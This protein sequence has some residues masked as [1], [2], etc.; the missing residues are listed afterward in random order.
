[1]NIRVVGAALLI[2]LCA[3]GGT[4]AAQGKGTENQDAKTERHGWLGVAV[5]DLTPRTSRE[6]GL[7]V[8]T[9]ALVNGVT[10]E[11][12]AEE[13][14]I[15]EDDVIVEFN[16]RSIDDADDLLAA[17]RGASAGDRATVTL[18]RGKE[19]TT[20][21]VTLG[22][23]PRRGFAFSYRG[24]GRMMIPPFGPMRELR[25]DHTDGI[26]GLWLTDLHR[27]LGEYFGAPGGRGVLIEE[28]EPKSEGER[29]GFKAGDVIISA[30]TTSVETTG[31]I[32]DAVEGSKK[33]DKIEFGVLR[34]GEHLTLTAESEGPAEHRRGGF[35]SFRF[36]GEARPGFEPDRLKLEMER[37]RDG[38]REIGTRIRTEMR[39][40]GR[41]LRSVTS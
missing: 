22:R 26:S 35:R 7:P 15:K 14:G 41:K 36:N 40:L 27:Q 3:T 28:V 24:P 31:D 38:L 17:V 23:A 6:K 13:A 16:G 5:Q 29:A 10:E 25:M 11:S 19:K 8:K 21:Q 37:L 32:A 33:G 1:M 4:S 34:K 39:D 2:A 12:P 20:V 9:G 18:C 30:G